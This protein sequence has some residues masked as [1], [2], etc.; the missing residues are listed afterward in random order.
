VE[1]VS[2]RDRRRIPGASKSLG[3][4]LHQSSVDV[5]GGHVRRAEHLAEQGSVVPAP[6]A[7]LQDPVA[8]LRTERFEHLRHDRRHRR[9]AA[10]ERV[11]DVP[12]MY[13]YSSLDTPA[14]HSSCCS[15]RELSMI[16]HDESASR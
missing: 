10:C 8:G 3:G 15:D 11:V 5:H 12:A 4:G 13:R 14:S 7:D 9:R 1:P 2:G 16:S 6:R